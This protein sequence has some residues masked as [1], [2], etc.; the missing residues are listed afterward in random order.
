MS[1]KVA[2]DVKLELGPQTESVDVEG[3]APLL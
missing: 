2:M 3:A 1:D